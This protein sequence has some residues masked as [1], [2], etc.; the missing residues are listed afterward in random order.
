MQQK[1]LGNANNLYM[2]AFCSVGKALVLRLQP[3]QFFIYLQPRYGLIASNFPK[4]ASIF[5]N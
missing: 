2:G 4:G 1:Y 3:T 5:I